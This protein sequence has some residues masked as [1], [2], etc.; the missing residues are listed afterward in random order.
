MFIRFGR[1]IFDLCLSALNYTKKITCVVDSFNTGFYSTGY[2]IK[3]ESRST[4]YCT[5]TSGYVLS[6]M[7]V[8]LFIRTVPS[9][10]LVYRLL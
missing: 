5:L 9:K 4:V 6:W 3:S 10:P 7:P 2:I 1:L 8:F